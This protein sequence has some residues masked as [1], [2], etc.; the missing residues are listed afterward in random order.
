MRL[1]FDHAVSRSNRRAYLIALAAVAAAFAVRLVAQG[2]VG[3]NHPYS[4]FFPVVLLCA[5]AFGRGPAVFAAGLSAALAYW[6]FVEPRF[7]VSVSLDSTGPLLV[8]LFT[9]GVAIYLIT[10]LT[11]AVRSLAADQGRLRA[12]ADEHAGLFRDLQGRIGHHM[13]LLMGVLTLQARGEPDPEV[14]LLLRKAGERSELIARAHRDLAGGGP[15]HVD[16]AA[17]AQSLARMM[18]RDSGQQSV[19]IE[20]TGGPLIIPTEAATSLGVALVE[21]LAWI[22]RHH[23]AGTIRVNLEPDDTDIRVFVSLAGE[24]GQAPDVMAPAAFMF[25]AMVE[26]LGAVVRVDVDGP[27]GAGLELTVPIPPTPPG[28]A[29]SATLH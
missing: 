3:A 22:L 21:C 6:V 10:G 17:F 26:Q 7:S 1:S 11:T 18:R 14:L 9:A 28:A 2:V 12:T 29:G 24:L 23:P 8:F 13:S 15:D 20:V 4:L 19:S 25:R 16:F 27:E 5:Y